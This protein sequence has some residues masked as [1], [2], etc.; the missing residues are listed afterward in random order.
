[1]DSSHLEEAVGFVVHVSLT[2]FQKECV[3][4]NLTA[5]IILQLLLIGFSV[6]N[7]FTDQ[8]VSRHASPLPLSVRL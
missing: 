8:N 2:V 6:N 5:E 4:L 7:A 1:M 3:T